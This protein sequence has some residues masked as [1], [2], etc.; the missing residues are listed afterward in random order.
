[1]IRMLRETA[2]PLCVTAECGVDRSRDVIAW[3]WWPLERSGSLFVL[4]VRVLLRRVVGDWRGC[5]FAKCGISEEF[6]PSINII[7]QSV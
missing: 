1:M 2:G 7:A 5:Y 3:G 6:E 4:A